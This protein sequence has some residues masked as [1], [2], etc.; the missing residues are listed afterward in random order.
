M[1]GVAWWSQTAGSNALQDPTINWQ[2]GQ[3]PSSVNDSARAMMASTA[4][5]R[6]DISGAIVTAGTSTAYT[7]SSNQTFD[8]LPR[9]AGQ[10][11]AFTP[12]TT[13]TGTCT[14]NVDGLGAKPLR[15]AP[16][17]E[18]PGG[19]L[20]QGTPY[21]ALY[22]NTDGAFYLHG[23][24]GN[25]YNIPLAGCIEYWGVTAPNS[26]FVFPVGQAISRT[27]YSGLFSLVGTTYGTGDGTTTFNLPDKRGRVAAAIDNMGGVAAGRL[28]SDFF[29]APQLGIAAGSQFHVLSTTEIPSHRHSAFI[30]DPG[31]T[32]SSNAAIN[33]GG[34]STGGG[35]FGLNSPGGATISLAVTGISIASGDGATNATS[36][37]GGSNGH[38]IVQPTICCNYILRII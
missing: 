24:F 15:S 11:I 36:L 30:S 25:A 13:Q 32:H 23:F 28:T 29:A 5:W 7:V 31:H 12:H 2:E 6:D 20:V 19:T 1:T 37:T 10:L 9:L 16:S 8:N 35:G 34:A 26:S 21:I 14:I 38:A 18:L 22:N 4:K 27:T 33:A 3:A 17:V